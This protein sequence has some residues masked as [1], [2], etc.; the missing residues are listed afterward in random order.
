MI[1]LPTIPKNIPI[2]FKEIIFFRIKASGRLK[3]VT[4]IIK[5][6]AV[7]SSIP[8]LVKTSISGIIPAAFEYIGI[9]IITAIG[10]A[11]GFPAPVYEAIKSVG[12]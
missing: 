11:K 10:T 9:P 12:T 6:S 3:A 5:L 7:P 1:P 8:L 2:I 4:A